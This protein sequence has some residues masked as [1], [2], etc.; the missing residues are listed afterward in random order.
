MLASFCPDARSLFSEG[1]IEVYADTFP[2]GRDTFLT[3]ISENGLK[4]L[5]AY[6]DEA[7][8]QGMIKQLRDKN[9]L[10]PPGMGALV[11][12][13]KYAEILV[14][15]EWLPSDL[16]L[17]SK[18]GNPFSRKWSIWHLEY[19]QPKPCMNVFQNDVHPS[20][21]N[22]YS[23]SV[24]AI[25][26]TDPIHAKKLNPDSFPL[27]SKALQSMLAWAEQCVT[28]VD[29]STTEKPTPGRIRAGGHCA[30][31]NSTSHITTEMTKSVLGARFSGASVL[32]QKAP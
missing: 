7:M 28:L 15:P 21:Y 18:M 11:D 10:P 9:A 32:P 20:L 31:M 2:D 5:V 24:W 1:G 19:D 29:R 26:E 13:V 6:Q 3:Q 4:V 12:N 27:W 17:G 23:S 25:A 8:R 14:M 16:V 22:A 30:T